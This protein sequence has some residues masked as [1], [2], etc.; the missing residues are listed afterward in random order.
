MTVQRHLDYA[1]LKRSLAFFVKRYVP[2][3]ILS[4]KAHPIRVLGR[5]EKRGAYTFS[6]LGSR[7]SRRGLVAAIDLNRHGGS[8]NR[9]YLIHIA[10]SD[11]S[12]SRS[13]LEM[14]KH[15]DCCKM[16]SEATRVR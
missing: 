13:I 9:R 7:L 5:M 16:T 2:M 11:T 1:K 8:V 3:E 14:G 12:I 10:V 4:L 6:F 15:D